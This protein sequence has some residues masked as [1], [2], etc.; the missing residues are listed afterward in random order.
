MTP[1]YVLLIAA[2]IERMKADLERLEKQVAHVAALIRSPDIE[3]KDQSRQAHN[4]TEV[5]K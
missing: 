1:D 4:Q 2:K 3:A 5:S